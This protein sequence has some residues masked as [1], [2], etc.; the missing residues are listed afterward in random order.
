MPPLADLEDLERKLQKR[1]FRRDDLYFHSCETCKEQAVAKYII[2]GR[3]GGRD[4]WLC[5]ACGASKSFRNNAGLHEREEDTAF[6]LRA[7]LA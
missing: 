3:T 5:H 6:D 4:I 2:M 1:G 7:F